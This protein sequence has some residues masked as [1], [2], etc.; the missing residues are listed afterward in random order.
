MATQLLKISA[1]YAAFFNRAPDKEGLD[2][3]DAEMTANGGDFRAIAQSFA[4]HPVFDATYGAMTNQQFVEA[5]YVNMLGGTGDA[6]GIAYWVN[7]LNNGLDHADMV[8]DFVT[9]ALEVD[10]QALLDN[11]DL[12]QA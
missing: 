5:I 6:G 2:D 4:D 10:L 9:G 11:G 12:T 1:L 8:A 3:W 7:E